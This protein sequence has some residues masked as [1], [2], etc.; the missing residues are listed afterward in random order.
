MAKSEE[1]STLPSDST[2]DQIK[3]VLAETLISA[4]IP[5]A[6]KVGEKAYDQIR[7]QEPIRVTVLDSK[8]VKGQH[9]ISFTLTNQTDHGAYLESVSVVAPQGPCTIELTHSRMGDV[10]SNWLPMYLGPWGGDVTFDVKIP[11]CQNRGLDSD[12]SGTLNL[13]VSRLNQEKIDNRK[14][15]FRLRW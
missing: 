8:L 3:M 2:K 14:I 15:T 1:H 5:V 9:E 4:L 6:S 10:P 7:S 11:L 13:E 12:L